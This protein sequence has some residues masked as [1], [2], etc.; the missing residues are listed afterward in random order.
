M[1]MPL[2]RE[3]SYRRFGV[4]LPPSGSSRP[5]RFFS[6]S[7]NLKSE[8]LLFS[9]NSVT[10]CKS[11]RNQ[12]PERLNLH[13]HRWEKLK[14]RKLHAMYSHSETKFYRRISATEVATEGDFVGWTEGK[15]YTNCVGYKG[16]VET[17]VGVRADDISLLA[18]RS[19]CSVHED[20]YETSKCFRQRQN[21]LS[22]QLT[23]QFTPSSEALR[24][25]RFWI[26]AMV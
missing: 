18:R 25:E 11:I 3:Y 1:C 21:Y 8:A 5:I 13:Q 7:L 16:R 6:Y 20:R 4:E 26:V 14:S 23:F 15:N 12:I 10:F 22:F 9:E 2:K 24:M 17:K 19:H